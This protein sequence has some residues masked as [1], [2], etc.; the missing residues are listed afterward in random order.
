MAAIPQA[1]GEAR[2]PVFGDFG[3]PALGLSKWPRFALL[4][5]SLYNCFMAN[6]I[7]LPDTTSTSKYYSSI[8][9]GYCI[10]CPRHFTYWE[11]KMTTDKTGVTAKKTAIDKALA[12]AK[13]AAKPTVKLTTTKAGSIPKPAAKKPE[14]KPKV[15]VVHERFSMPKAEYRKIAEIKETCLEAGL[16]VKK[17]EVLRAGLSALD[18]MNAAQLKSAIVGLGK[19][20]TGHPKKP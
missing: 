10:Y 20:K 7:K 18:K 19:V 14:K 11:K 8:L 3:M 6:P 12:T 13:K 15:K 5:I 2:V 9:G 1:G 4:T 17:S 16:R